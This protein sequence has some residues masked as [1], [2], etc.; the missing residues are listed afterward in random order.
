LA[1]GSRRLVKWSR[2]QYSSSSVS[3]KKSGN[4]AVVPRSPCSTF[5]GTVVTWP[6]PCPGARYPSSVAAS[7]HSTWGTTW[8]LDSRM[9]QGV[10]LALGCFT[11]SYQRSAR[12]SVRRINYL[13]HRLHRNYVV[14][15]NHGR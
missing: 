8:A 3:S 12:W 2:S 11:M 9:S 13:P 14:S 1:T 5:H 10:S 15:K 6:S 7:C 4:G